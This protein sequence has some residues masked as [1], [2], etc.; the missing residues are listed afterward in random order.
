MPWTNTKKAR[1]STCVKCLFVSVVLSMRTSTVQLLPRHSL[2]L[3]DPAWCRH[4]DVCT[5]GIQGAEAFVGALTRYKR[6]DLLARYCVLPVRRVL[7]SFSVP[8]SSPLSSAIACR[9][10][11]L[12]KRWHQKVLEGVG[13][14]LAHQGVGR[15]L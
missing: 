6:P 3:L 8:C 4:Q 7:P 10:L 2:Q 15:V 14:G 11:A 1:T 5:M 13:L 12:Q 9:R